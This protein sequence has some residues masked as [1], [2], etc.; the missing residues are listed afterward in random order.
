MSD[1]RSRLRRFALGLIWRI[2]D[3]LL[4]GIAI[5]FAHRELQRQLTDQTR[6][7]VQSV[8]ELAGQLDGWPKSIE[9]AR[10]AYDEE[11]GRRDTIERK[12]V[13]LVTASGVISGLITAAGVVA[14]LVPQEITN[15]GQI[16]VGTALLVPV[17][18]LV[19]GFLLAVQS[20]RVGRVE[21]IGPWTLRE[22]SGHPRPIRDAE[23][24]AERIVVTELNQ[25]LTLMRVNY[26][27]SAERWIMRGTLFIALA[28]LT[29][30]I[31]A[32]ATGLLTSDTA[33]KEIA[34]IDI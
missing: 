2:D 7:R 25:I 27:N 14:I 17:A 34:N 16:A 20:W 21:L 8:T 29:L 6:N 13:S 19:I 23:L 31:L 32:T 9:E 12:A 26:L 30:L 10:I 33:T 11:L 28:A 3:F 4:P 22:L 24:A 1:L 15:E 5:P 18:A